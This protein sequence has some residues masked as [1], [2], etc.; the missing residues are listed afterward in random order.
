MNTHLH[1][2]IMMF[3]VALLYAEYKEWHVFGKGAKLALLHCL[4]DQFCGQNQYWH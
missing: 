4:P 3:Y 2:H 1:L